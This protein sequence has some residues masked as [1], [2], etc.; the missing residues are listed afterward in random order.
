MTHDIDPADVDHT[1][2]TAV[3]SAGRT[4]GAL[5]VEDERLDQE[6]AAD[7]V[8]TAGTMT[9]QPGVRSLAENGDNLPTVQVRVSQHTRDRLESIAESRF[10]T[11]AALAR[12]VLEEFV[13]G[14]PEG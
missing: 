12:K 11:V 6:R 2:N 4:P 5:A 1:E 3:D 8:A 7:G 10:M 9:L 14:Q 13:K